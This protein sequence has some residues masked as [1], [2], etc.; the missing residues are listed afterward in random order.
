MTQAYFKVIHIVSRGDLYRTCSLFRIRIF[1]S[2]DRDLLVQQR[3]DHLFADH[4]LI[5]FVTGMNGN[6]FIAEY[7][8]RS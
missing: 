8:L 4:I 2:D 3:D 5:S 7:G 1:V 6:S